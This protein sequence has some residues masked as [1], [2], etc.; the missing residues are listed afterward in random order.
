MNARDVQNR[1]NP[2]ETRFEKPNHPGESGGK[3]SLWDKISDLSL[4]TTADR[5]KF[6]FVFVLI[7]LGVI[8]IGD[9]LK[10]I[11]LKGTGIAFQ[12]MGWLLIAV[13]FLGPFFKFMDEHQ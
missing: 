13:G 9:V 2:S 4:D 8:L 11:P 5:I 1:K 12:I 7:G 6:L 3:V 10:L